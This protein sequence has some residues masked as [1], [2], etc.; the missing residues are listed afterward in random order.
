MI[1]YKKTLTYIKKVL[2]WNI[3][4]EKLKKFITTTA[5]LSEVRIITF[6]ICLHILKNMKSKFEQS[7]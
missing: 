5:K 6:I 4:D 3:N 1:D 7:I 2:T